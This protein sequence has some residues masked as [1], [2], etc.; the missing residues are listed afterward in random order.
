[1]KL[2]QSFAYQCD[3]IDYQD[4]ESLPCHRVLHSTVGQGSEEEAGESRHH[5]GNGR[6]GREDSATATGG[7]ERRVEELEK[8]LDNQS[9]G[10]SQGLKTRKTDAFQSAFANG[11]LLEVNTVASYNL[12]HGIWNVIIL[13]GREGV[14]FPLSSIC[15]CSCIVLLSLQKNIPI[16]L[17]IPHK[18]CPNSRIVLELATTPGLLFISI[19][20]MIYTTGFQ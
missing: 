4:C 20:S 17:F 16:C 14:M 10:S 19:C 7:L 15:I 18:S 3:T 8:V 5:Q 6:H 1:M 2:A 11:T 12:K 9:V 13:Q